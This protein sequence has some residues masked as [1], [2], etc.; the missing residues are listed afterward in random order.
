M[1]AINKVTLVGY[2]GKDPEARYT[3]SGKLVA[4]FSVAITERWKDHSG[5]KKERTE[6]INIEAWEKLGEICREYLHKGSQVFIEGKLKTDKYEKDGVTHYFTKVVAREMQ[7]LDR[8]NWSGEYEPAVAAPEQPESD[9]LPEDD[10][11]F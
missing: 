4:S 3:P 9:P 7:M 2:L 5:E 11:P 10:I 8:K 6:W 1:A